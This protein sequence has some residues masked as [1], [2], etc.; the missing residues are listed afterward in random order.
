MTERTVVKRSL[1]VGG[2][3]LSVEI[4]RVA[5]QASGAALGRYGDTMVL[6]AVTHAQLREGLD[7]FPL[8]VDFE[9]RHYSVGRIP[10]S[11]LKREGRPG[12]KAIL[13]A[14]IIDRCIRP[15]FPSQFRRD[16]HVVDTILS[17]EQDCAPIVTALFATSCALAVSDVPF[18]G[19]VAGVIIGRVDGLLVVNP[20]L[21]QMARSDLNLTVAGHGSAVNMVECGAHEVSEDV[22]LE[23]IA[24]GHS[25]IKRIVSFIEEV[26]QECLALGLAKDKM[27]VEAAEPDS[28]IV[29]MV[30]PQATEKIRD[31]VLYY[32]DNRLDK[33]SRED[34]LEQLKEELV[35]N[36]LEA[37]P[38]HEAV[39]RQIIETAE[40]EVFRN[41]IVRD[42][43]RID[44]RA[45][46]E[47]RQISVDAGV[48][49]R[50][51]GSGLFQRGQTQVLSVVTLG[52]LSDEQI[53]DNLTPEETK[54]FMHHYNFPSYS[55]G[56]TRPIRSPGRREIGH[57]A[58]GER[59]LEPIIPADDKFP[60]TLRI[61]SE[62]LSSNGSSS[63]ASICG[64]TLALLDAGVPIKAPV[65]GIAM[66]L[67]KEGEDVIILTDIQGVEDHLG[68]MDFKVAGTKDGVTA[69]QMDIKI[70]GVSYEVL[71]RALAQAR[72]ARLYILSRINEL[73]PEPRAELSPLAP[74]VLHTV[75]EPDKIRDV[76]GPGGKVIRKI[77]EETGAEIDI[78][79]DGR[80]FITA[81]NGETAKKA[82]SV[83]ESITAEVEVGKIYLGRVTKCMD[84]GCFV[85]VIPGVLGLPGKEGLVHISQLAPVR[86][87]A[88]EDVVREGDQIM[89]KAIGYD[90]QGRL[91]LSKKEAMTAEE[92]AAAGEQAG[93][94]AGDPPRRGERERRPRMRGGFR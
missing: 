65:A 29:E 15:L 63:M 4:G 86:I 60:Y 32:R 40:K 51:H 3:V 23:A 59:A 61:V 16:V 79:D 13:S 75:I 12:E 93:G 89:V 46:D 21:E 26:R 25:E 24:L 54:R 9:E 77:T 44:G 47:I 56:E 83:I 80:C 43:I 14:R 73:L 68:D 87:R 10:G 30:K 20:T 66:G 8:T 81:P 35:A 1:T 58:L 72:E 52:P 11:F 7:F 90:Q 49:P 41:L 34:H 84:F 53:V 39:I 70:S 78:E 22:L 76:I 62:V 33:K 64:S 92:R 36:G 37:F 42:K 2:R 50:A 27:A 17:V 28:E 5:E 74:R 19:P 45:T 71:A 69:L 67:I 48:L 57:G 31:A 18:N 6:G 85:E 94:Q 91:K 88:V 82:L 38:E 55:T